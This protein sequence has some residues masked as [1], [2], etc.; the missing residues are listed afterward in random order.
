MHSQKN[1]T[2]LGI[3]D[4]QHPIQLQN[5]NG[6]TQH[7][8]GKCSATAYEAELHEA[9]LARHIQ[10]FL[11]DLSTQITPVFW[12]QR[13]QS[14]QKELRASSVEFHID[15]PFFISKKAPVS[16]MEGLME[17]ECS[18][19]ASSK[20]EELVTTLKV[21]VTTLC[22]CSKEISDG[23]AHNQR[24]EAI[25]TVHMTEHIWI[26][27][28]IVLIEKSASCEVYSVLKRPD[29]KYVTEKAFH[30]PMFV[31][32]VVRKI[33]VEASNH[34]LIEKFSISVES[35]ESIHKHSA[36]AYVDSDDLQQS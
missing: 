32:D 9:D 19:Q 33:A 21:P 6:T 29:E 26:E 25:F 10:S 7:S 12:N 13:L 36:Y 14:I 22:P 28:L 3:T 34:P 24:A 2:T 30:N 15:F 35:F 17:Y 11:P 1:C 8:I 16:G 18:F 5:S 27:E 31:E 4:L 23:G 20:R